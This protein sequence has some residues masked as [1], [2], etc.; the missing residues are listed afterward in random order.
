MYI[1]ILCILFF[2]RNVLEDGLWVVT[3][4]GNVVYHYYGAGQS[5]DAHLNL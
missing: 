5:S 2:Y 4:V 1:I 3:A